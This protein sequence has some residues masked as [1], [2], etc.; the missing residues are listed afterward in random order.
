[1]TGDV[2]AWPRLPVFTKLQE[3]GNVAWPEMYRTFNMGIGMILIVDEKDVEKVKENL[4]SRGE[5]VYEI[6][7]IVS[8]DGPVVLKGLSSMRNS[9]KRLA[10]FASGRGSNGEALYTAMQEGYINGEFVVIITD[11]GDAGL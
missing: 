11:H 5:A 9:K 2:T 7:R 6:G 1:M 10:L 8:G 4:G 3:W